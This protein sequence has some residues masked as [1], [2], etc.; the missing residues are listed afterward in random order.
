MMK[1]RR[2]VVEDDITVEVCIEITR[3]TI[4]DDLDMPLRG[5]QLVT[6]TTGNIGTAK[7]KLSC[8]YLVWHNSPSARMCDGYNSCPVCLSVCMCVCVCL[9]HLFCLLA[10][11]GVQQ[12][13]SEAIYSVEN[14]VKLISD[15]R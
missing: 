14:S 7:G 3:G 4:A 5:L 9:L 15:F 6:E 1:L 13:V 2:T 8:A 10:C 12:A 11:L